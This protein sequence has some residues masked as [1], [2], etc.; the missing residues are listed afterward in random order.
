MAKTSHEGMDEGLYI[1]LYIYHH[2]GA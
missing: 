2:S 1:C